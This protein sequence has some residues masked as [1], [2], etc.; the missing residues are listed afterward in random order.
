MN[1]EESD[2]IDQQCAKKSDAETLENGVHCRT[3]QST[4]QAG[5]HPKPTNERTSATNREE[6]AKRRES[7]EPVQPLTTD[8]ISRVTLKAEEKRKDQSLSSV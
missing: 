3:E 6:R 1:E 4:K 7:E 2:Q 8:F 5:S